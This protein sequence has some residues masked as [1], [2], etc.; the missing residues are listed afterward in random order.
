MKLAD[1]TAHRALAYVAAVSKHGYALSVEEF[2]AY[3]LQPLR[4]GGQSA[5]A[6]ALSKIQVT[7]LGAVT[8][9]EEVLDWLERLGWLHAFDRVTITPLGRA[10]LASL[11]DEQQAEELPTEIVLDRDDELSYARV[12]GAI[13]ESGPCAL[14]DRY[15]GLESLLDIILRTRVE[16]LLVGTDPSSAGRVAAVAQAVTNLTIDRPFEVRASARFHDRFVIPTSGP[17]RFLGTSL[18]GVG[19]RLAISGVISDDT[20]DAIRQTFESAWSDANPIA[21]A[22]KPPKPEPEPEQSEEAPD[23]QSD[24]A[25]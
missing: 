8:P 20:A 1:S 24:Q 9:D 18:G 19:K 13:A 22:A 7:M 3:M 5:L 10:V 21:T 11:E 6:S 14:V 15:F 12:I 4:R 16:R 25:A 23:S 2:D 17:V